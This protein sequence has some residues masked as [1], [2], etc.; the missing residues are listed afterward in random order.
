MHQLMR[1]N[2]YIYQNVNNSKIESNDEHNDLLIF[3]INEIPNYRRKR[4]KLMKTETWMLDFVFVIYIEIRIC[5]EYF[6]LK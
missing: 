1:S 3:T 4:N 6:H 5:I 2:Q